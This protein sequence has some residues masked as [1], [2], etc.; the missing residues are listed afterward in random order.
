MRDSLLTRIR[1]ERLLSGVDWRPTALPANAILCIRKAADPLPNSFPLSASSLQPSYEWQ[2]ALTSMLNRFA[3]QAVRPLTKV[4]LPD[5]EAVLFLDDAELLAC[6][7]VDW[8]RGSLT[9]NWWWRGILGDRNLAAVVKL[10]TRKSQYIPAALQ[11]LAMINVAVP[12]VVHLPDATCRQLACTVAHSFGATALW[13]LLDVAVAR[14]VL[15][16]SV[17]STE[18]KRTQPATMTRDSAAEYPPWRALVPEADSSLLSFDQQRF[19]CV[20]LM[21][22]RASSQARS[23]DFA[24]A[25]ER[26]Q[27]SITQDSRNFPTGSD[28]KTP[29]L[30]DASSP[31]GRQEGS[32]EFSATSADQLAGQ[33]SAEDRVARKVKTWEA[34]SEHVEKQPATELTAEELV[35]PDAERVASTNNVTPPQPEPVSSLSENQTQF[36][37]AISEGHQDATD[38]PQSQPVPVTP[39][40]ELFERPLINFETQ[41]GGLFYLINLGAYLNLYSD[42]TSPL[43]PELN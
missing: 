41:L 20:G 36:D 28:T 15:H 40:I 33:R 35:L 34:K 2:Q 12:F 19:L 25:L 21:I 4:V 30:Q 5:S 23:R 14:K 8:R 27:S 32:G 42:F 1:L 18:L 7:A 11:H 26:W 31:T 37:E 17:N 16:E 3:S 43:A 24:R 38:L 10:W 6:L 29:P 22:Y 9:T 13:Q 39:Q